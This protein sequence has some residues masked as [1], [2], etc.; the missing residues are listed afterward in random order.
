MANPRDVNNLLLHDLHD[1]QIVNLDTTLRETLH[2]HYPHYPASS[3]ELA[4]PPP[5]RRRPLSRGRRLYHLPSSADFAAGRGG[6]HQVP[7]VSWSPCRRSHRAGGAPPHQT[8]CGSPSCLRAKSKRSASGASTF[9]ATL[10]LNPY[11][12]SR[13]GPVTRSPSFRWLGQWALVSL[14]SA[15]QATGRL[16]LAP[17]GLSPTEHVCLSGHALCGARVMDDE[18]IPAGAGFRSVSHPSGLALYRRDASHDCSCSITASA[19]PLDPGPTGYSR[20][21]RAPPTARTPGCLDNEIGRS[22]AATAI[23]DVAL[24]ARTP[25]VRSLG[26]KAAI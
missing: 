25:P 5:S 14:C 9:G 7:D 26:G 15:I 10:T 23:P 4:H 17:V 3:L 21:R 6:P 13:Y 2:P 8:A 11:V 16:A 1:K 20:S 19:G 18:P 24:C 12:H 22:G